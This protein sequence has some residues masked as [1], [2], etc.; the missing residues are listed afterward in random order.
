MNSQTIHLAH[1]VRDLELAS[2]GP[3]RCIPQFVEALDQLP[4]EDAWIQHL[5]FGD[6][7]N[8]NV[9]LKTTDG[10]RAHG[11]KGAL[12]GLRPNGLAD[13]L[14]SIHSQDHAIQ[15]V[16]VNGLW[17]P[18][19]HRVIKWA[20]SR[21]IPYVVSPHGM[22]SNWCFNHKRLKKRIG[23][24]L[25][26][27]SDLQRA[28]AVHVTSEAEK[29]DVRGLG[30][31]SPILVVPNGTHV[32]TTPRSTQEK[33]TRVALCITRLHPVKGLDMLIDAWASLRPENWKLIIAGP[34]EEGM[35]ERLIA[36]IAKLKLVD[37]VE[38][39]GEVD[40]TAKS[41]LFALSD[42]FVLPS[43]SENFGMSIAESLAIGVPVVTTTGT[44]WSDV[45]SYN[46]GWIVPPRTADLTGALRLALAAKPAKLFEMGQ[47]GRQLI[48]D[49]FT[50][51][52]VALRMRTAYE[53]IMQTGNANTAGRDAGAVNTIS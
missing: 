16:H 44:P 18:T 50:W 24:W 34:S 35:R 13:E 17:S 37:Q 5:V 48:L 47:R 23:W 38:L 11:V 43:Q 3:S 32:N 22:L 30:I 7:G 53:S 46:C 42:L 52:A 12:A 6:R 21:Q 19:L 8:A 9:K 25:Y 27:R 45:S 33:P 36:Q 49:K 29:T 2:G 40:D 31:T 1:V 39:Q 14:Q 15:L 41:K 28:A 20:Q 51:P 10:F 26:Q 4:T